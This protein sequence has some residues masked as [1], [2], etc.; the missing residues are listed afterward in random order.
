MKMDHISLWKNFGM[1]KYETLSSINKIVYAN[2]KIIL[3][4]LHLERKTEPSI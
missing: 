1:A 4:K 3:F 2:E